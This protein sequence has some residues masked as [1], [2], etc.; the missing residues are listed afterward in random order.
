MAT[1]GS[2]LALWQARHVAAL[3]GERADVEVE[4]VVVQTT[5]DRRRDVPIHAI[6]GQ[7]VFVKE[8]QAA[9]LGGGAD[10]AVHSAKDLPPRAAPGLELAAVPTRGDARDA[11]AGCALA[12]LPPGAL[13]ATGSVRRRA[14]LAWLRPD[15]TFT[16]L[17][18]NIETR[19]SRVGQVDAVVVAAAALERLGQLER[20]AEVLPVSTLLPQVAQGALALEARAD[21]RDVLELLRAVEDPVSRRHVDAER[22][23]LDEL[24]GGCDLPVGALASGAGETLTVEV[25]LASPDGRVLIRRTLTGPASDPDALGRAAAADLMEA[26]GASLMSAAS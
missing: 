11:L 13:V 4:E 24:G 18:G 22:A 3:L 2:P 16:Q 26:G 17:R 25:L 10:L 5:G 12:D 1:R 14:Q 9:V 15:L 21:A 20:A 23:F 8:V 6:G 19:L 7:G